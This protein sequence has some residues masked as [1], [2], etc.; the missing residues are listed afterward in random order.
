MLILWILGGSILV[1]VGALMGSIWALAR[2]PRIT[3][4]KLKGGK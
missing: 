3:V 1:I 2:S 4:K